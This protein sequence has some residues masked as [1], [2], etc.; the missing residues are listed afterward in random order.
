MLCSNGHE[1]MSGS[2]FC[3]VC[4]ESVT[5]VPAAPIGTSAAPIIN[6][7]TVKAPARSKA[8]L[9]GG[10]AALGLLG[11]GVGGYY[12]L[13][14]S[15]AEPIAEPPT[16]VVTVT[17]TTVEVPESNDA[18]TNQPAAVAAP[19]TSPDMAANPTVTETAPSGNNID[20]Q[21][22]NPTAGPAIAIPAPT[23][24]QQLPPTTVVVT[25]TVIPQPTVIVTP[26]PTPTSGYY[27]CYNGS[28]GYS[29]DIPNS[30][31][32]LSDSC[33]QFQTADGSVV[34]QM[35]ACTGDGF[36]NLQNLYD[37]Y[38]Y[39]YQDVDITYQAIRTNRFVLSGYNPNGTEFYNAVWAGRSNINEFY[40]QSPPNTSYPVSDWITHMYNTFSPGDLDMD[41]GVYEDG[42]GNLTHNPCPS[43]LH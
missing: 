37:I 32:A 34:L 14:R 28:Y 31:I 18:N 42:Y 1:I 9:I 25:P 26:I 11:A 6:D 16:I 23:I 30:L 8:P 13:G 29:I 5:V 27:T 21:I 38:Q 4:G 10:L 12:L 43:Y 40:I 19:I 7:P 3:N 22:A 24:A 35:F 41:L 36:G 15:S 20:I 2:K 17:A 39:N 33:E